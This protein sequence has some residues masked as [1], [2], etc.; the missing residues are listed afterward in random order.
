[1]DSI[2]SHRSLGNRESKPVR[3]PDI[4]GHTYNRLTALERAGKDRR[5]NAFFLCK[6]SCGNTAIVMGSKVRNGTT[7]SCGCLKGKPITDITGNRYNRFVVLKLV[8][9]EDNR[10]LWLCR[11][12]CG[13]EKVLCGGNIKRTESCG[14][15]QKERAAARLTTHGMSRTRADRF[16]KGAKHRAKRMGLP[17]NLTIHLVAELLRKTKNCPIC[18]ITLATGKDNSRGNMANASLDKLIPS[19]GYVQGNVNIICRRCNMI[20][21]NASSDELRHIADWIDKCLEMRQ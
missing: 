13:V 8:G 16:L 3:L 4:I 20:K 11:C 6:C 18:G 15:I 10:T 17:I 14:C 19:L 12:D 7:R 9:R 5:G 21:L 2:S 1:M